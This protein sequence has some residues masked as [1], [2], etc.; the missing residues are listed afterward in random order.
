MPYLDDDIVDLR[1]DD[2]T[3][4]Q[5]YW[6]DEVEIVSQDAK[7]FRIRILG[8]NGPLDEG[9]VRKDTKFRDDALL[10]LSMVDVQQGDGMILETPGGKRIF[11]DGGD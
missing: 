8:L 2:N 3:T 10:R 6:G 5:Y 7:G 1:R 9:S 11:V 4:R